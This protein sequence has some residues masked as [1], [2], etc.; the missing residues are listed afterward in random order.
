M[1]EAEQ[2]REFVMNADKR[3]KEQQMQMQ[4]DAKAKSIENSKYAEALKK[5]QPQTPNG[6]ETLA[7]KND[8]I[9][10]EATKQANSPEAKKAQALREYE[11]K[12]KELTPNSEIDAVEPPPAY[13]PGA[14]PS[15]S[16]ID[17]IRKRKD[18]AKDIENPN[19]YST[20]REYRAR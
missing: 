6:V 16:I 14:D 13:A 20:M 8:R 9:R 10:A 1:T 15:D 2:Y 19:P 3:K 7:Q 4:E 11:A 12:M 5:A 17:R 18:A